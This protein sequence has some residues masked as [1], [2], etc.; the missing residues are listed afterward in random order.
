MNTLTRANL[1]AR[2]RRLLATGVLPLRSDDQKFFGGHGVGQTCACCGSAI[3]AS[4]VL[5]E[6]ECV[7]GSPALTMHLR[8]LE[9]WEVESRICAPSWPQRL[10]L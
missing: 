5:Y 9:A 3:S 2:V 6:I 1:R 10:A 4:E 8:C 7:E